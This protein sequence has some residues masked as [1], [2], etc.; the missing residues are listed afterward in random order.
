ML[1]LTLSGKNLARVTSTRFLGVVFDEHLSWHEHVALVRGKLASGVYAL[2]KLRH[3]FPIKTLLM[4]Y[5]AL[6]TSHISYAIE[7][8]GLTYPTT[9]RPLYMLQKKALRV[10]L[11]IPP[12]ETISFAFR[13]MSVLDIFTL[14][15][16]RTCLTAHKILNTNFHITNV[17]L[18]K[19]TSSYELRKD[20]FMLTLPYPRTN[21][22]TYSF[23]YFASK[24]WNEL[25]PHLRTTAQFHTFKCELREFFMLQTPTPE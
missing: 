25:T 12:P 7:T 17:E 1:E 3:C 18:R 13:A 19:Y 6:F 21:Y 11:C 9:L 10:C 22:L 16:F 24:V 5:H 4:V 14:I 23:S 15:K 8:Y 20:E 2:A